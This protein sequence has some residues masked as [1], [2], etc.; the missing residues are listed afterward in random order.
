MA[1][2]RLRE[3]AVRG[4][5]GMTATVRLRLP[6]LLREH[7]GGAAVLEIDVDTTGTVGDVL[8]ALIKPWPALERRI[9]DERGEIRR[10]VNVFVGEVHVRDS[11][12]LATPVPAGAEI[13][14]IPA[15]SGG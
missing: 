4:G 15:V 10:H 5:D 14:V 1:E 12:G 6:A 8:D 2:G 3:D 13:H 7:A 9:R 11:G